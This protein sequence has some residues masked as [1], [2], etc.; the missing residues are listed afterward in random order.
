MNLKKRLG[1]LAT[2]VIALAF[3]WVTN[4]AAESTQL[5][6]MDSVDLTCPAG[7]AATEVH[8]VAILLQLKTSLGTVDC[9]LFLFQGTPLGLASPQLIH[10]KKKFIN[11]KI[12]STECTMTEIS[13]ES[14]KKVLKMGTELAL[15][16][17]EGSETKVVCGAFLNCNYGGE[18]TGH[19]RGPNL[20]GG[21][22]EVTYNEVTLKKIS[23]VFCP[24]TAK[25]T[26]AL[27][28]L[29]KVFI[30]S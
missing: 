23:G 14:L 22:S 28:D 21:A 7:Q 24:E 20:T 5:C 25:L 9:E 1:I 2:A 29:V 18:I 3:A 15:E 8:R 13:L 10:G 27:K 4:A 30:R 11:C 16:T 12:G 26:A 6:K 19:Y 17:E